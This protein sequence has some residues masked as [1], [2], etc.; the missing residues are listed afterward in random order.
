MVSSSGIISTVAGNF[1]NGYT[2]DGGLAVSAELSSPKGIAVDAL[3]RL[4]IA[5]YDNNVVRIVRSFTAVNTVAGS[6]LRVYP[7]PAN[8]ILTIE[9]PAIVNSSDITLTDV[10]GKTVKKMTVT[11]G[12]QKVNIPLHDISAGSYFLRVQAGEQVWREKITVW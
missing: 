7:N 9:L 6:T 1:T 5:D 4:Y 2:G 8:N 11:S 3:N 12:S 10:L